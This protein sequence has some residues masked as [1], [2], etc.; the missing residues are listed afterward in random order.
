MKEIILVKNGEIA[1]KGL[2]RNTFEHILIKN[3][4][5]KL[6][7]LGNFSLFKS[8]ST[9][10]IEPLSDNINLDLVIN[11]LSKVF[12][13]AL[14]SRALVLPKNMEQIKSDSLSYLKKYLD[15]AKTFKVE[16]KR[17]D[18]SFSLI[19]PQISAELG[20]H[21][22]SKFNNLSVDVNNPDVCVNVEI[23]EKNAFI[24]CEKI[25]GARGM[26][27][28]SSGN[29]L[30]LI[31]GG[32][33]SPVAGFMMAKR[34]INLSAIH[35]I[36]PPYT[37]KQA[38]KKVE[39]LCLK[40]CDYCNSITL[41]SIHFTDI[42]VA[43]K[44]HCEPDL[45]YTSK[46]ALKKVEDLC[47]KLC[48]YCN[49]ITLYSIHF[50]DIQ[51]AIKEHCEPDLF[52]IIMRRIMFFISQEIAI[53]N[54]INCLITG[55]SIAQV[56]SQTLDSIYCTNDICKMPV[57]RPVIGMDKNE[58]IDIAKKIDTFD[59]SILPYEDCCTIFTPKHPRTK[60]KLQ[61]VKKSE[62]SYNF[63]PLIENAIN[64]VSIKTIKSIL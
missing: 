21:L 33:D 29:G 18:K 19:S 16:S 49:S 31:S 64:N 41:Y 1:L 47:L 60:P 42:Q 50:T 62:D 6:K 63:L 35:F 54:N 30:L 10:Y 40:L 25:N 46:Q 36:S 45:F 53:K 22:L 23:R 15:N 20:H 32:I 7:G 43:I 52:T 39:D 28:S 57:F 24:H 59:I 5:I 2:N 38:L 55:E 61:Y 37:S 58:I 56:A 48:D 26:P 13:I 27:L 14:L 51:V 9:I 17:A 11:K 3:I 12:G 34:G 44:E 4:K 8:Q